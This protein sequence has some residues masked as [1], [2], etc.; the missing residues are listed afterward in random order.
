M[1]QYK[2]VSFC[3]G[4]DCIFEGLNVTINK[5]DYVLII[6][7][8]GAGKSTFINLLL[9]LITPE[10]GEI[11]YD[12]IPLKRFEAW[13]KIGYVAQRVS[14]LR[15]GMPVSVYEV[16]AMGILGSVSRAEVVEKLR[17]LDLSDYIDKNIHD[18]SGGQQQRVFIA[19]ALMSDPDILILDE[20]TV[21]L[22]VQTIRRF[23]TLIAELHK[24][25]KTII[26]VTHDM[27]V[28]SEEATRIIAI[29]DGIA[30]DGAQRDY[31]IWHDELCVYC[32]SAHE[33]EATS[34]KTK[35]NKQTWK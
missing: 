11:T 3:Y 32:G 20:P 5:G 14:L 18:L 8:N 28:L 35:E 25:G 26:M 2:D 33:A 6:G 23:Y 19:R 17:L 22:D 10:S 31:R 4:R 16:V 24:M 15:V 12:G 30:F 7:P 21:G 1:I 29:N 9:G 13:D 34:A 27:H